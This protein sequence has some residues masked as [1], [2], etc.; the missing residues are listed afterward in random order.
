M[1]SLKQRLEKMLE[2]GND[3][4]L[5]RFGLGKA[6]A[7]MRCYGEAIIHLEQAVSYDARHSSSWFWLGRSHYEQ[8]RFEEAQ[9][10]LERAVQV[11]SENGDS[12]TVNM[13]R[14]F[15]RRIARL[16]SSRE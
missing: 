10:L 1:P 9:T 3:H 14:V 12:Q 4:L 13:A 2:A 11:A 16:D 6:C 15:L 5:L 8:G 7:E